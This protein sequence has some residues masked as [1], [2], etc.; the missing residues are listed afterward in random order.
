MQIDDSSWDV[1]LFREL[2]SE[3]KKVLG[4][5]R[6]Y[7][8]IEPLASR[9]DLKDQ[10]DFDKIPIETLLD[11]SHYGGGKFGQQEVDDITGQSSGALWADHRRDIIE[12][13][14]ARKERGVDVFVDIEGIGSGKTHKF[15]TILR[16]DVMRVLTRVSP[17]EYYGLDPTGQGISFVCMSRNASLAKMVTFTTVLKAFD[18][19]FI[20]EHFPPQVDLEKIKSSMRYPSLLRFPKDVII[21]PGTGSALSAV[22]YNLMGGG[23]DEANWLE[24]V[25]GSK[26]AILSGHYDAGEVMYH[27][28]KA[29]MRSRFAHWIKTHGRL[30]GMLMLFSNARHSGDFLERMATK[31]RTDKTIFVR[32]R[33][34]WDAQ[35]KERFSG[36]TFF[37][38]I[39]NRQIVTEAGKPIPN[40]RELFSEDTRS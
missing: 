3:T 39:V 18:C 4:R 33:N 21:F 32:R 35:P 1:P 36:K 37:F 8:K 7:G 10:E 38:D 5:D 29:R 34:T 9:W 11:D 27:A 40:P 14:R 30:P 2:V 26:K 17:L 22:G 23:I 24:V 16:I 13:D 19:P 12:L 20:N 25:E 31:A 15:R 6:A 28:I